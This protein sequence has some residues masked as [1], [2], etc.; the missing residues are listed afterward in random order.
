MPSPTVTSRRRAAD[1]TKMRQWSILTVV[2]VIVVFA[3]GWFLLVKPEKS[4]S[5][6]LRSTAA[7][8][9]QTNQVLQSDIARLQDEEKSLPAKQAALRKFTTQVPDNAAEPTVIRQL[10]AAAAGS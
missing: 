7:Q 4:K 5:T 3:A 1:M 10:S 9:Q 6:N 2:A 8:Q